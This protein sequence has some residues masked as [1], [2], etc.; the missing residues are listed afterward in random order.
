MNRFG[1]DVA[2][3]YD[4]ETADMPVEPVVEFLEALAGGGAALLPEPLNHLRREVD[5]GNANAPRR[6]RQGD[7]AGADPFT[8]ES[9]RHVSVWGKA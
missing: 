6:Q 4:A 7:P 9:G 8:S 3:R 1:E 5:S 2:A